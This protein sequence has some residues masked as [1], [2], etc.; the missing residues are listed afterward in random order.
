LSAWQKISSNKNL[1]KSERFYPVFLISIFLSMVLT[2]RLYKGDKP[3]YF[4]LSFTIFIFIFLA[5]TFNICQ[6]FCNRKLRNVI[7]INILFIL[8]LLETM[9]FYK[10]T[11]NSSRNAYRDFQ[12]LFRFVNQN[13]DSKI[14]IVPMNQELVV[15]LT[16]Y[17]DNDQI[18]KEADVNIKYNLFVCYRDCIHYQANACHKSNITKYDLVNYTDFSAYFPYYNYSDSS[19]KKVFS[20]KSVKAVLIR[21][22][23]PND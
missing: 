5:L 11:I 1:N 13:S 17:F 2:L 22:E 14:A 10:L 8:G 6:Q 20:S 12:N 3:D 4:L 15:P 23:I 21:Q 7:F 9:A 19:S 16:Y 18:K